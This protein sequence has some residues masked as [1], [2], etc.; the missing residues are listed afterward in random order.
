MHDY[1][2]GCEVKFIS[3]ELYTKSL[4][5]SSLGVSIKHRGF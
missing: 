2:L 5:A 1:I 3:C 4:K